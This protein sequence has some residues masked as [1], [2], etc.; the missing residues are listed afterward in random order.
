MLLRAP[1]GFNG[2]PSAT[3]RALSRWRH[4]IFLQRAQAPGDKGVRIA[5][6]VPGGV[7]RSGE[8]RVIPALI[9]FIH[10]LAL[11]DEVH[12]LALRQE[13]NACD[14]D[15]AG[16]R[17]HS[18][19]SRRTR[20]RAVRLLCEMHRSSHFALVHAIWSGA[21]GQVAVAAAALLGIP[22]LIHVAGGELVALPEIGYGSRLRWRGRISEGIVLRAASAI[23][24]ASTP[25]IEMISRLGLTAERVPLGVDLDTWPAR[26]PVRRPV[27]RAAR[28]VHVASLNRVKDQ[29]TLLRALAALTQH[30]VSF[31][32]DVVG[33]DTLQGEI[34]GLA[35]QLGLSTRVRFHGFL[36]RGRLRPI[37]EAADL[38][39]VSSRHETGPVA[40]LEAAVAG[41]PSVGT[42]V[43]HIVE[44]APNAAVA[45]PV[46]DWAS[47]AGAIVKLLDDEELRL[48][49]AR[50][51]QR[52]AL[53]ED[54]DYTVER[55]RALYARLAHRN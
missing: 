12:V 53:A 5:L 43:G 48:S 30:G 7:D 25:V 47:M 16:A 33:E 11:Q 27:G 9:A 44:W 8:Y 14:W 17:I 45:V 10:R 4:V 19:G 38:M 52:R 35:A 2:E 13:D 54:A 29:A 28:L 34:Q 3:A 20:L 18:V 23:T 37:V 6:V 40:V 1:D 39:I 15:L 32:T 22:S 49:I 51:A 21:C 55:F 46:G 42:C 50:E 36:T 24:A 41:V 31:E 26:A